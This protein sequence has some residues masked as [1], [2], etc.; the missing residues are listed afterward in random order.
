MKLRRDWKHARSL[1]TTRRIGS[2]M[3]TSMKINALTATA[4]SVRKA[5]A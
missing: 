5:T 4:E 3:A 2:G 1:D